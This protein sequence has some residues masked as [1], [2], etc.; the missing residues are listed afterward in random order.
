[1]VRSLGQPTAATQQEGSEPLVVA[2]VTWEGVGTRAYAD[3][4]TGSWE[5]RILKF[6]GVTSQKHAD[7]L[8]MTSSCNITLSD[9]D[10]DL[11]SILM[12]SRMEG[13]GVTIKVYFDG[14]AGS[15]TTIFKGRVSAPIEWNDAD[16]SL[17]FDIETFIESDQ[18]GFELESGQFGVNNDVAVGKPWPMVFGKAAHVPS[19]FVQ[20]Q[21]HSEL[22]NPISLVN[23]VQNR[24]FRAFVD[25]NGLHEIITLK[26][27]NLQTE[28][29]ASI[30]TATLAVT[31]TDKFYVEDG[32]RFPQGEEIK[33]NIDGVIFKGTFSGHLFTISESN[34]K[35]YENLAI[36]DR[37][38]ADPDYKNPKVL[39]LT[40]SSK[41][42][43]NHFCY[44]ESPDPNSTD[45]E[46]VRLFENRCVKQ[47]GRKCWF[48]YPFLKGFVPGADNTTVD[49]KNK[50]WEFPVSGCKIDYV[51]KL[52]PSGL[53]IEIEEFFIHM[54][55]RLRQYKHS[56]STQDQ[57]KNPY[58]AL[59]AQLDMI[60][61]CRTAFFHAD[62]GTTVRQWDDN[63]DI[64][65]CNMFP[66]A[67][68]HSVYAVR[69]VK[70]K[71]K[72]C[73]IPKSYYT[74]NLSHA[75]NITNGPTA[76]TISFIEPLDTFE[77][78]GWDKETIYVTVN[79]TITSNTANIIKFILDNYT[80]LDTNSSS[81]SSVANDLTNY[82]SHFFYDGV[83]DALEFCQQVAWQCRCA[84]ILDSD[85]VKIKYL[86]KSDGV[87]L[88]LDSDEV[89][90]QSARISQTPQE[91]ILTR[92][93]GKWK[94][95]GAP[96]EFDILRRA[97]FYDNIDVYGLKQR[98]YDFFIYND[99]T[100]VEKTLRFW[101]HRYANVWRIVEVDAFTDALKL[102]VFDKVDIDLPSGILSFDNN[103]CIVEQVHHDIHAALCPLRLWVPVRA[104][105]TGQYAYAWLSDGSDVAPANV[106][107]RFE[108][109]EFDVQMPEDRLELDEVMREIRKLQNYTTRAVRVKAIHEDESDRYEVEPV[110]HVL[111]DDPPDEAL[112]FTREKTWAFSPN[113]YQDIRIGDIAI[114]MSGQDGV[115]I[116]V[117]KMST[118]TH[119][120]YIAAENRE[121]GRN[122]TG[123]MYRVA[124]KDFTTTGGNKV[125]TS[126]E[127]SGQDTIY[128]D[129][130]CLQEMALYSQT[131][132]TDVLESTGFLPD[133]TVVS[134]NV[135][136]TK[137]GE[138]VFW[139][140]TGTLSGEDVGEYLGMVHQVVAQNIGGWG[141]PRYTAPL[142]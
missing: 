126:F 70:G 71:R 127:R 78:Q 18:L 99:G 128:V 52:H 60:K 141:W 133:G 73:Q 53:L 27:V 129:A 20:E 89:L 50:Q 66:S 93:Y 118:T 140:D 31:E 2:Y 138:T 79:S 67:S 113:P 29:K 142:P 74:V 61:Y 14:A 37:D 6:S 102:E 100:L 86:S 117:D 130:A 17:S 49:P 132:T 68:I 8:G 34:C 22:T 84:L 38:S 83:V 28:V 15:A 122:T 119:I 101:G 63:P 54:K 40:N 7:D 41:S 108:E 124:V 58:G 47:V 64:Y 114:M 116:L 19:V 98:E 13:S 105:S 139:F 91:D 16:R 136:S 43:V 95:T 103:S 57:T 94:Y 90:F 137:T 82:P 35:K 104:G 56:L 88:T 3:K 62:T 76:T 131:P 97:W 135:S 46:T 115:N 42:I 92:L 77:G 21:P 32:Y 123:Y 33:V 5:G 23:L 26:N 112:A 36:D 96:V 9:H 110:A 24:A 12:A 125:I 87:D 85:D 48:E 55:D 11:H 106:A 10:A 1:M 39:W 30:D 72:F 109:R 25:T 4:E 69:E 120:G 75:T 44:W 121:D 81:F 107:D 51:R 45:P 111:F 134:L 80:N 65:V 59:M